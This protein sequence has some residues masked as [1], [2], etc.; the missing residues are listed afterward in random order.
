LPFARRSPDKLGN[1]PL[2][3]ALNQPGQLLAVGADLAGD[4][5]G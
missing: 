3:L 5:F 4:Q 2:K 1:D